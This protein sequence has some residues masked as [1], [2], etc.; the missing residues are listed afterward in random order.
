VKRCN[1]WLGITG[2]RRVM[3]EVEKVHQTLRKPAQKKSGEA[4]AS[5]DLKN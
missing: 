4:F 2:T 1:S 5:P 3:T